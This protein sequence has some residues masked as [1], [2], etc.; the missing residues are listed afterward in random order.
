MIPD[1]WDEWEP[2]R[3]TLL[4]YFTP[5][6]ASVLKQFGALLCELALLSEYQE[7]RDPGNLLTT[8]LQAATADLRYLGGFLEVLGALQTESQLSPAEIELSRRAATASRAVERLIREIE[9]ELSVARSPTEV[10]PD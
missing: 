4:M 5:E 1:H 10:G 9:G 7:G 6:H 3:E 8:R 2:F